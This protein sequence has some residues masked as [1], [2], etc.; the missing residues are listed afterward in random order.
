MVRF[1]RMLAAAVLLASAPAL[2]QK[3]CTKADADAA[4]KAADRVSSWA[5]LHSAWKSYRHCDSGEVADLLT[6][7]LLRLIVDWKQ[8]DQLATAMKDPDYED[9]VISHLRSP[10]AKNDVEDVYSRAKKSCPP[11]LSAWCSSLAA[12]IDSAPPKPIVMEPAASPAP[13]S[14]KK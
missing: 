11:A 2:A 7:A 12:A 14:E 8:V 6:E 1:L 10:A 13:V 5:A 3:A 4:S 9:F